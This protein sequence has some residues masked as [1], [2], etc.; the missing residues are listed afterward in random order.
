METNERSKVGK[1][2]VTRSASGLIYVECS[3]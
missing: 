2:K 1:W 3:I